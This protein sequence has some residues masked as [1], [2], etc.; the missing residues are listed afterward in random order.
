[1]RGVGLQSAQNDLTNGRIH[2]WTVALKIFFD[3]PILGA[4]LDAFGVALRA[5]TPGTGFTR[6]AGAQ[7]YLQ[8]LTDAGI[9]GFICVAAFIWLLFKY[10]LAAMNLRRA[11]FRRS[12][13]HGALAGCFGIL[14]HSLFDFPLRTPSECAFL[15]TL[16]TLATV[17]ILLSETEKSRSEDKIQ[18][19]REKC[20]IDESCDSLGI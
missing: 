12:V 3:Y 13:A 9:V 18:R 17:A 14:I 8:T 19:S 20:R 4:G 7:R 5:T 1:V 6:R 16:A 10:G 15:L 2:F 11:F